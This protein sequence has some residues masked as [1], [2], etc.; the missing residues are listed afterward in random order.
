MTTRE[1]VVVMSRVSGTLSDVK[2]IL[3]ERVDPGLYIQIREMLNDCQE[4]LAAHC[5]C[6]PI[7][8][9]SGDVD[10]ILENLQVRIP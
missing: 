8:L 4:M 3:S 10:T 6:A 2:H 5:D 7:R 9:I 1:T